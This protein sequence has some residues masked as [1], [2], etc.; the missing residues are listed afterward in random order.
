MNT[1]AAYIQSFL[2]ITLMSD[3]E[4]DKDLLEAYR[5][6]EV[7]LLKKIDGLTDGM[8]DDPSYLKSLVGSELT[9]EQIFDFVDTTKPVI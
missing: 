9:D 7:A 6:C 4:Y 5:K 2:T 3:N 8:F 1:L